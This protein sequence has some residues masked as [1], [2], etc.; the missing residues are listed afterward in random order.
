MPGRVLSAIARRDLLDGGKYKIIEIITKFDAIAPNQKVALFDEQSLRVIRVASSD[1][2]GVVTFSN[3]AHDNRPLLLVVFDS[4]N[5]LASPT[6]RRV[7]TLT[8]YIT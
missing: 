1:S 5:I 6:V 7:A 8:G 4:N 2:N 3:L